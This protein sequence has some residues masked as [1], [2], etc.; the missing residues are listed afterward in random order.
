[1]GTMGTDRTA[2]G[3]RA[4]GR[5]PP[6]SIDASLPWADDRRR[7]ARSRSPAR[8]RT[9]KRG[10]C[11]PRS[12]LEETLTNNV[13]LEPTSI[14]RGDLISQITPALGISGK[15]A[16]ASLDGSIALPILL[17]VNTG[18]ENN[19]VEP[20]VE[21]RRQC[22]AGGAIPV[23]RRGGQRVAAVPVA[24]RRAPGQ[25]RQRDGQSLHV[26]ALSHF[27]LHQGR[28][29]GPDQLR[30]ARRQHLESSE[31]CADVVRRRSDQHGE[32]VHQPGDR[33]DYP[34]SGPL[35]LAARLRPRRTFASR[36]RVLNLPSSAGCACCIRWIRRCRSG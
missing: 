13:N 35:R 26:A 24:V 6:A 34:R 11:L 7:W 33:Q 12:Q 2:D 17:Y 8:P 3:S 10:V 1:M 14:R 23:H 32:F 30:A 28:S 22:R 27:A 19:R 18:A 29:V 15:S 5:V 20:Q 25:P 36:I 9:P 21:S 16:H 31:R 4:N